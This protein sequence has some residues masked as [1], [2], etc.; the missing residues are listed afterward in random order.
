MVKKEKVETPKV[1]QPH[2][3]FFKS[4]LSHKRE[5]QDL[6]RYHLPPEVLATIDL[7]SIEVVKTDFIKQDLQDRY[8]D[9]VL[10]TKIGGQIGYIYTLA[11][12]LSEPD[13]KIFYRLIEYNNELMA[14]HL[15]EGN[16]KYPSI[17]NIVIYAG[18]KK[19]NMPTN[20][21]DMA[22]DPT[23][24]SIPLRYHL[25]D[26]NGLSDEELLGHGAIA[27]LEL[28]LKHNRERKFY[29]WALRNRGLFRKFLLSCDYSK[30]VIVYLTSTEVADRGDYPNKLAKLV[31]ELK[32]EIMTVANRLREEGIAQGI[33]Q[34]MA[35]GGENMLKTLLAKGFITAEQSKII[36]E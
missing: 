6:L 16:K 24:V 3:K 5:S 25:V 13:K 32:D 28:I 23:T 19:Y 22:E 17:V 30:V 27:F 8:S 2:D 15:A 36:R 35:Q 11:E 20:L 4:V 34:G 31:P 1:H 18:A 14:R 9:L 33:A 10:R 21:T 29:Q 26:L 7:E 12:H